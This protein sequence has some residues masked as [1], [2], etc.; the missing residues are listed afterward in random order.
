MA[1][2]CH[3]EDGERESTI[4]DTVEDRGDGA[5]GEAGPEDG[6]SRAR[7][8]RYPRRDRR[9]R[10]GRRR[11]FAIR[12]GFAPGAGTDAR[13]RLAWRRPS[14]RR[15]TSAVRFLPAGVA[16]PCSHCTTAVALTPTKRA[17]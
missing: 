6:A 10:A 5:A 2:F 8:G 1:A 9:E 7:T 3:T 12:R 4:G 16:R 15:P 13:S 17:T 11:D 14:R